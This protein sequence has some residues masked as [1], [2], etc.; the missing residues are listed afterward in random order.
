MSGGSESDG[1]EKSTKLNIQGIPREQAIR[2]LFLLAFQDEHLEG[3]DF[4]AFEVSIADAVYS[5]PK[6]HDILVSGN[7]IH[8]V[9]GCK[10]YGLTAEQ[11]NATKGSTDD[12]YTR[13]KNC[14]FAWLYLGSIRRIA[15]T[16][17]VEEAV[18]EQLV[19]WLAWEFP[20]I[21]KKQKELVKRF[22]P[23][24]QP[25]GPGTAIHST[26]PEEY[27]ESLL[28]FKRY[29]TLEWAIIRGLYK[30]AN[31]YP[32]EWDSIRGEIRR[33]DRLQTMARACCSALY[34]AIFGLQGH[35]ARAAANHYIQSPGAQITKKLQRNIWDLQPIG[36]GPWVVRP[37]NAHDEVLCPTTLC[38]Q[39]SNHTLITSQPMDSTLM[40][41][42]TQVVLDTIEQLRCKVPL[43]AM[44]WKPNLKNWGEK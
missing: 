9:V 44:K 6:L 16:G 13:S 1:A 5:D 38:Y 26:E 42:S 25:M 28:G 40:N 29:F 4:D 2:S 27:A 8:T 7:K 18:A 33:T 14:F 24:Q 43:L 30:L 3:G 35:V 17:N 41:S 12:K 21:A 11:V 39:I 19:K 15:K 20:E 32:N 31:H 34:A 36:I 37:V 10:L 23:L 22:T